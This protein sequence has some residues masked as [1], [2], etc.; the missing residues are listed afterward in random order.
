[1]LRPAVL[2]LAAVLIPLAVPA[3]TQEETFGESIDV[4]VV[5]VETVVTD[6]K[7]N[8]VTGLTAGDFRLLVDGVEVPV[9]YFTEVADGVALSAPQAAESGVAAPAA[10][11]VGRNYLVFVD[12]SVLIAPD[13]DLVLQELERDLD[14]LGSGDRMALVAFDGT[15]LHRLAD[16]TGDRAVLANAFA[17][18][19]KRPALGIRFNVM[20]GFAAPETEGEDDMSK[21]LDNAGLDRFKGL[22]GKHD[23]QDAISILEHAWLT[24]VSTAAAA[25]LR[26][27]EL[28]VGRKSMLLLTGGWPLPELI[29]PVVQEANRLGYTLYPIDVPGMEAGAVVDIQ[30]VA[31]AAKLS[32][33]ATSGW[34]L[35]VHATMNQMARATGGRTALNGARLDALARAE[36]DTRSYYWL[37]FSPGWKLDDRH[38]RIEVVMRRPGLVVRARNGFSDLSPAKLA[39]MEA[40]SVLLFGPRPGSV[41]GPL[42]IEFGEAKRIKRRLL[43]VPVL[44]SFRPGALEPAPVQGRETELVLTVGSLDRNGVRS[45]LPQMPLRFTLPF[46]A[47]GSTLIR[48]RLTVQ[49]RSIKQRLVFQLRDPVSGGSFVSE[50]SYLPGK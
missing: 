6:R 11:P 15:Q 46:G 24:R 1:M 48:S 50:V 43:E 47:D 38:H 44:V 2:L 8:L 27:F 37:G 22:P 34:E 5:N 49:L 36:E 32:G 28:P 4:R 31:P 35:G 3:Q 26:G 30:Q 45:D 9:D 33:I 13:R 10:G 19:R 23:D 39:E 42:E 14:R 16:W 41:L 12:E 21:A 17:E 25:A 29:E 7:G 18:A 20:R 40:E